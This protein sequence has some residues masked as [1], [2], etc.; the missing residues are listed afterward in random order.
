[1]SE[2]EHDRLQG[3]LTDAVEKLDQFYAGGELDQPWLGFDAYLRHL[4]GRVE[5]ATAAL[6]RYEAQP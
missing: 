3:K 2:T 5:D 4:L 6:R 1:M